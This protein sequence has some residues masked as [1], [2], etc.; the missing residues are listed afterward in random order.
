MPKASPKP[1]DQSQG[2]IQGT[3][4]Y[5][6]PGGRGRGRGRGRGF[7]NYQNFNR[8]Q[9]YQEWDIQQ[10]R[11]S[12]IP[13]EKVRQDNY[14]MKND[15]RGAR[16]KEYRTRNDYSPNRRNKSDYYDNM[17]SDHRNDDK[18][19]RQDYNRYRNNRR[20]PTPVKEYYTQDYVDKKDR[21]ESSPNDRPK[22]RDISR[23]RPSSGDISRQ[24]AN[25]QVRKKEKHM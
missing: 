21:R 7:G 4:T 13:E 3:L 6:P 5:A 2:D 10:S 8:A 17:D 12:N 23:D 18:F 20:E 11:G 19:E 9:T 1:R 25:K 16:P 22:S 15:E 14:T 24:K